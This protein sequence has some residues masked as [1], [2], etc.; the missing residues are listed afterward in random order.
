MSTLHLLRICALSAIVTS[1]VIQLSAQE[2]IGQAYSPSPQC[3][4]RPYDPK[5]TDYKS[6]ISGYQTGP[7]RGS[8]GN[9]RQFELTVTVIDGDDL[10]PPD[11][12][13][14][15]CATTT[16]FSV[17]SDGTVSMT[18]LTPG[19]VQGAGPGKLPEES[20][21]ILRPLI[22]SLAAHPPDDYSRLPPPGRR[23]ILQVSH[24]KRVLARV[25]DRADLPLSVLALFGLLGATH[26]PLTMNFP[27]NQT[28]TATEFDDQG[29][30][31]DI[32]GLRRPNPR[33]PITNGLRG[34]TAILAISPDQSV[35]VTR[36][37]W[38]NSRTEIINARNSTV[39]HTVRE[40]ELNRREIYISHASC[41][42]DNRFVLLLSNLPAIMIYDTKTG[43]EVNTLPDLPSGA[44]AYY[45]S[46]DWNHGLAVSTSG[47]AYL[48]DATA[49]RK[50]A[51]LALDGEVLH[52]SFSPDDSLF[53]VT[54][55]RHNKDQ[56]STFRLRIWETKTGRFIRELRS[57]YYFE[58]D[59]IGNPL[60]W[61]DGKYLLAADRE[62]RFGNYVVG[63][64]NTESGKFRGGFSGC[65]D[66]TNDP[67]SVALAGQKLIQR[68][69]DNKL[70]M[71]DVPAAIN[72]ITEFENSLDS[73]P[74]KQVRRL[75]IDTEPDSEPRTQ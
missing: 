70:L 26:G 53:A 1:G 9:P 65:S 16:S 57:L 68:C 48:W 7:L 61:G 66:S 34:D 47:E 40:T 25:Y 59:G 3:A 5:D 60:W 42:P 21:E 10:K 58:I 23:A 74:G 54:T 55:V 75:G 30:P 24:G 63:I 36:H 12:Y 15:S 62:G 52:V 29:I 35:I 39:L 45:P 27:P 49:G 64:W 32:P 31:L 6:W 69:P 72:K 22:A 11:N 4:L 38:I 50:L 13:P 33:D 17:S 44:V 41:T 37:F 71:W 67:L 51:P 2:W 46:S 73:R 56:S 19:A 43:Q 28:G 20:L 14:L 8:L 18:R